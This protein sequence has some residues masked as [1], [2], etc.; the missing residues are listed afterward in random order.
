M[1]LRVLTINFHHLKEGSHFLDMRLLIDVY[2]V[3]QGQYSSTNRLNFINQLRELNLNCHEE[4][5]NSI[6]EIELLRCQG[7]VLL[8]CFHRIKLICIFVDKLCFCVVILIRN[9]FVA[10]IWT[11]LVLFVF[12]LDQ[13]AIFALTFLA[14]TFKN[15]LLLRGPWTSKLNTFRL[16]DQ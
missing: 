5:W 1:E 12:V 9:C 13:I 11:G 2:Y 15:T 7:E 4:D 6:V 14:I 3:I 8:K 16:L 10:F